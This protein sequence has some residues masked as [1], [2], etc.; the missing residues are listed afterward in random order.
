MHLYEI[1]DA[2]RA[3]MDAGLDTET[4]EISEDF[5]EQLDALDIALDEKIENCAAMIRNLKA[6]AQAY[7]MEAARMAAKARTAKGRADW[8]KRY[9]RGTMEALGR[10]KVKGKLLSV[11]L[12]AGRQSVDV[13]TEADVPDAYKETIATVHVDKRAILAHHKAT[14][15]DVP[16]VTVRRGDK[17]VKIT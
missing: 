5:A 3:A 16:G 1:T 13:T 4:G 15:E 9:V 12:Q 7:E 8:L 11:S 6:E 17:I 10:D 14:G 2:I